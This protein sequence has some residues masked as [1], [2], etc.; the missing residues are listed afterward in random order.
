MSKPS[1]PGSRLTSL[2]SQPSNMTS[3]DRFEPAPMQIRKQISIFVPLSDWRLI[4][5]EA[6]R[7]RIPI[8]ELCRRWMRPE[9]ADLR[10]RFDPARD[11]YNGD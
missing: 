3:P 11:P 10:R 1:D 5:Q 4:R 2:G 6:A 8:T 9:M 7:K